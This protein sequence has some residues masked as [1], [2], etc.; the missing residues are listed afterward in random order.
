MCLNIF[1]QSKKKKGGGQFLKLKMYNNLLKFRI[2]TAWVHFYM[3]GQDCL[4]S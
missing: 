1:Y 2:S 3:F 4:Y